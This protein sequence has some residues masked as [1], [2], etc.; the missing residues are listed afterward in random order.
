MRAAAVAATKAHRTARPASAFDSYRWEGRLRSAGPSGNMSS[1][2]DCG[3]S[4]TGCILQSPPRSTLNPSS[5]TGVPFC[6]AAVVADVVVA[7]AAAAASICTFLWA[8][9]PRTSQ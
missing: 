3:S 6:A 2:S 8:R 5:Q 4:R 7:A 9:L 1:A